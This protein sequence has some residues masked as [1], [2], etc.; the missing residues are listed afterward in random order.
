M[1]TTAQATAPAATTPAA[2]SPMRRRT[3]T[4]ARPV[5]GSWSIAVLVGSVAW[6]LA[7]GHGLRLA[8]ARG[9]GRYGGIREFAGRPHHG[10]GCPWAVGT[11]RPSR[12]PRAVRRRLRWRRWRPPVDRGP[13]RRLR[14]AGAGSSSGCRSLVL[15]WPWAGPGRAGPIR[16]SGSGRGCRSDPGRGSGVRYGGGV[17][18]GRGFPAAQVARLV[19][20]FVRGPVPGRRRPPRARATRLSV[21]RRGPGC[22]CPAGRRT[23]AS[24]ASSSSRPGR[25]VGSFSRR[26]ARMS[27]NPAAPAGSSGSS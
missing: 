16:L 1:A 5:P 26:A 22:S 18:D 7:S 25:A 6:C 12:A 3:R 14:L 27:R 2:A 23:A 15:G 13:G 10:H 11:G 8:G 21:V 4:V 19:A 24:A 20:P 17:R 9:T